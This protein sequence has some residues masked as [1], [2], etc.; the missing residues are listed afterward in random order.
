MQQLLY[1]EEVRPI[2]EIEIPPTEVKDVE[3]KLAKQLIEAQASKAFDPNAYK[4]EVRDRIRNAI[5]KKVE[6]QEIT[7]TEA[8]ETG[9]QVIDLME[10][11]RASLEKKGAKPKAAEAKA[12]EPKAG[13]RKPAK[14]AQ[15]P[16]PSPAARKVRSK[17]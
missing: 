4:D 3:L 9:A 11:L 2:T 17:A 1:S 7:L 10:A 8:P 15:A 14:R 5:D 6:G 13:E 16:Q 12:A